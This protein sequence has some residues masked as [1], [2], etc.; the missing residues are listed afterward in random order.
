MP[1]P[2]LNH[3][4]VV[5]NNK[6]YIFGG[7]TI[8]QNE[9]PVSFVQEYD[10]LTNSWRLLE[11]MPFPISNFVCQKVDNFVY[12]IGGYLSS[13][14]LSEDVWRFNLDD[15][16]EGC[17]EVV[18]L[19]P[20][21]PFAVGD[22]FAMYLKCGFSDGNIIWSSD[23]E[24]V[25][26]ASVDGV[27]SCLA[28]GT[29]KISVT[30]N[31]GESSD[32]YLLTVIAPSTWKQMKSIP[33]ATSWYGSCIDTVSEKAYFFGGQAPSPSDAVSLI[34]TTQIYDFKTDTWSSGANMPKPASALSAEMVNGKIYLIGEYMNPPQLTNVL[35][36][37]PVNDIWTI[38]EF[39]PEIFWAHGSCV[40]NGLIYSFG[41]REVPFNLINTTRTYNPL[42]DTWNDLQDMPYKRD[43]PA[44]CV[45]KDE[46][47]L[48]GGN[49]SLKYTPSTN[50]WTELNAGECDILAYATPIIDGNRIILFGG[51]KEGSY[52][53]PSNEIWVYYPDND[54]FVRHEND[55]PFDRFTEGYKYNNNVYLFGGNFGNT[56]GS[57]TNEVWRFNLDS[58]KPMSSAVSNS[59]LINLNEVTIYPN[60]ANMQITIETGIQGPYIIE[61]T[62]LNG[63]LLLG[64]EVEGS[65]H[66][67]NLYPYPS[68]VYF[69]TLK[70]KDF[71]IA[72]KIIKY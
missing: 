39:L 22:T 48:F 72:R 1:V 42:T 47:Y 37:D 41:G 61:I 9:Y 62:T 23:N 2:V 14:R 69:I 70:S 67:L 56:L 4:S 31:D 28:E 59:N 49:P 66:Q 65:E 45:Y 33:Q 58:L 54:T 30:L 8:D 29:T 18:I 25:A 43:N 10:P 51:Y 7:D 11:N 60:P 52:P 35:E 24:E 27:I 15:L 53:V 5:Y 16:K 46:I 21:K 17:K 26:I 20:S 63:Q 36:Y 40:Y 68:G 19:E 32:S 12:L 44:V 3:G 50:T 71:A 13:S 57:V 38:K 34:S 6:I 64:K 55:M